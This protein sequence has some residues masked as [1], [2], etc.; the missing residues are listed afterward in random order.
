MMSRRT[1]MTRMK[2]VGVVL[3][4][5]LS[6]CVSKQQFDKYKSD[7]DAKLLKLQP[8]GSPS[9][10]IYYGR[11]LWLPSGGPQSEVNEVLSPNAGLAKPML[12]IV[13]GGLGPGGVVTRVAKLVFERD[14]TNAAVLLSAYG[15][16]P[17]LPVSLKGEI[18]QNQKNEIDI[19]YVD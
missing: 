19:S 14:M 5:I 1:S 11:V 12:G 16:D 2:I 13:S 10:D 3:S 18:K 15:G 4:L 6:G 17:N 9:G 7:T 8:A